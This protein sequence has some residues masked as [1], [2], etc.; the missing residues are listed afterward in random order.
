MKVCRVCQR[1]KPLTDYY[2]RVNRPSGTSICRACSVVRV[3]AWRGRPEAREKVRAANR[4][5]AQTEKG[6]A[7]RAVAEQSVRRKV[8]MDAYRKSAAG[9]LAQLRANKTPAGIARSARYFATEKGRAAVR[10]KQQ[11]VLGKANAA[12]SNHKRRMLLGGLSNLTASE[13]ATIQAQQAGLCAYCLT[14]AKLTMDHVVPLSL[15]GSNTMANVVGA[16]RPCNSAKKARTI[17]EWFGVA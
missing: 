16:C 14:A 10:R 9:K 3:R 6:R 8:Q 12:R 1:D 5:Y 4:R 11:T 7:S 15:G 13:W 17:E 2:P